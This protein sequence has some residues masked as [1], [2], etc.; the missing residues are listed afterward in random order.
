MRILLTVCLFLSLLRT[1]AQVDSGSHQ[2]IIVK[3]IYIKSLKKK[4]LKP[5]IQNID[6]LVLSH[7]QLSNLSELISAQSNVFVKNYGLGN[8]STISIRGSSS[9]QTQILWQGVA[10]NSATTGITD[11]AAIPIA[12]FDQVNI[13]YSASEEAGN[14]SGAIL[15]SSTKPTFQNAKN[16][17]LG[18]Q[19]ESVHNHYI[20]A[21]HKVSNKKILNTTSIQ[22]LRG[23]NKFT[24]YNP[25]T[26]LQ[27]TLNNASS[28]QLN[29][30]NTLYA[31]FSKN[32]LFQS[33]TWIQSTNRSIPPASFESHV[34]RHE[35]SRAIRQQFGI[36]LSPTNKAVQLSI[37]SAFIWENYHYADSVIQ[38]FRNY[39]SLQLPST[40]YIQY[41]KNKH[42]HF[43]LKAQYIHSTLLT[44]KATLNRAILSLM[45]QHDSIINNLS[46][47]ASLT[48]EINYLK[49]P[50]LSATLQAK[51]LLTQPLTLYSRLTKAYRIPTLN[52][53]Y[54]DPG[55]NPTLQPEHSFNIE[56]G[57]LLQH[58]PTQ[59]ISIQADIAHYYRSVRDW[60]L[61][62]GNAI[63]TPHNIALVHSRGIECMTTLRYQFHTHS[64][65]P[66]PSRA[67]GLHIH[68]AYTLS[69]TQAS[70]IPYDLSIG[71]QIPYTPRYQLRF[72]PELTLHPFRLLYTY[73]Y[74]GYRFIT[75]D[76]SQWL[77]PFSI[78][79]LH[80][81]HLFQHKTYQI[82]SGI[83]LHNILN[84]QYQTLVGRSMPGRYLSLSINISQH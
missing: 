69:T 30:T 83:I 18:Y 80:A 21:S 5:T 37:H 55:G 4:L 22:L 78:H 19:Y 59:K 72:N 6:S 79:N 16:I 38:L 45:Y 39:P 67:L 50:P 8:M 48:T 76:E 44:Q 62:Y 15:L 65:L 82:Q 33:D 27:D 20:T 66:L 2:N 13:Q 32:K 46:I 60:I 49:S 26:Q 29:L 31:N 47:N 68:Y 10:I 57:I 35:S 51:Y 43:Q 54:F 40:F 14:V 53:L 63:L 41:Q 9:A 11:I 64:S 71:R 3:D 36:H 28:Q 42:Q 56:N 1:Q 70:N 73:Q 58:I 34:N 84:H 81:Q 74:T 12:L 23:Q 25:D 24:F 7:Y 61:W 77:P 52:E 75:T 17:K